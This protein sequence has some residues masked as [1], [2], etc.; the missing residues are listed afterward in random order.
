MNGQG[1]LIQELI[2]VVRGQSSR[3]TG[4]T[5][6]DGQPIVSQVSLAV[7]HVLIPAT[8]YVSLPSLPTFDGTVHLHDSSNP[9][10]HA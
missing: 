4:W 9:E 10:N 6:P 1:Q 8:P 5:S 7:L 3:K 2:P